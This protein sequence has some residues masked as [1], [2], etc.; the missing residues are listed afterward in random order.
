MLLGPHQELERDRGAL[1]PAY[2]GDGRLIAEL[3]D[4][5]PVHLDDQVAHTL[6]PASS[7]EVPGCTWEI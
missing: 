4:L 6:S 5:F 7:A 3:G 2:F 1:F